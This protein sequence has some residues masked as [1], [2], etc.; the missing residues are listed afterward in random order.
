MLTSVLNTLSFG[1]PRPLVLADG[2]LSACANREAISAE[3]YLGGQRVT[4]IIEV[5]TRGRTQ[6]GDGRASHSS[7]S[8]STV[9]NRPQQGRRSGRRLQTLEGNS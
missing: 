6:V 1:Q 2:R 5:T 7:L 3:A 8:N 9:R 4:C